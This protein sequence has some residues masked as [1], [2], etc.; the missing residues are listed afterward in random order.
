MNAS[1]NYYS[2]ADTTM[3]YSPMSF[4][5]TSV[6]GC[7]E[8]LESGIHSTIF[9][10]GSADSSSNTMN[11]NWTPYIGWDENISSYELW[12]KKDHEG[13]FFKVSSFHPNQISWT[14]DWGERAFDHHFRIRALHSRL[15]FESWSNEIMLSFDHALEIPNVFTP[16]GDGVN[17]FFNFPKLELF[18]DN[19]LF[20]YNRMG[21]EVYYQANYRGDWAGWDLASGVYYFLFTENRNQKT[22]RGWVQILR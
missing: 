17:D 14:N 2:F 9:L 10:D 1:D 7:Q 12:Y 11:L 15:P 5:I 6:N 21:K 20:V 22:Y 16:N 8:L 4:R 3:N 18:Y 19:E 13:Q